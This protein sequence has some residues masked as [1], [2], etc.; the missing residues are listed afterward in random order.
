VPTVYLDNNATTQPD[1]AAVEAM[2]PFLTEHYA[3]PSSVHRPGQVARAA[4]EEARAKLAVLVGCRDRQLTFTGCGTEATNL[5]V[6]GLFAK[7]QRRRVLTTPVEHDA[8]R[9]VVEAL[10]DA[11]VE[12]VAVDADGRPVTDD[13]IARL[14]D[15]VALVSLIWANNETGVLSN[16]AA[17]CAA[18]RE[19][20]V[21]VHL[22]ATQAV[23][24]MRV[25]LTEVGCDAATFAPHKFHGIKGVG[26]L[27]V[28]R[29][30]RLPGFVVGGPQE[31]GLRGGTENVPGIVAA[32]VAA[33][34][35]MATMDQWPRVEAMRDDLERRVL[36]TCGEVRVN[37][38]PPRLGNTSNL[39]FRGLHAEALLLMLSEAGICASAGAACSSGSLEPS[40]VL[41]AAGVPEPWAFGS[42]R[43]SLSRMTTPADVDALC[44]TLPP[45]VQRL[46]RVMPTAA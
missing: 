26:V 28:R 8:T 10:P 33:E 15:D 14:G 24:K 46:R 41:L 12:E 2:L 22:D 6:R 30:L 25:D 44:E 32:G 17:I 16:A 35:A 34:R 40:R 9:A 7:R 1:P 42:V 45:I 38:G 13:L 20:G 19:A 37:G 31:R 39:G 21:P 36:A 4:I 3:N 18:C 29:G 27:Y 5:A 23:G 11:A 43:F